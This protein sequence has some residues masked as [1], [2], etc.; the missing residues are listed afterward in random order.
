MDIDRLT[1]RPTLRPV[2]GGLSGPAIHPVA[3]AMVHSVY[4][5]VRLPIVGIGGIMS[6]GDAVELMLA[7]AAAVQ[8]GTGN[9]RNPLLPI[10]V[11]EALPGFLE[12]YDMTA[13]R[14]LTGAMIETIGPGSVAR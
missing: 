10:E 9:F 12:R 8:V 4:R 7:G 1:R 11:I 14:E 2:T 13:A 3:V 5:A 6:P